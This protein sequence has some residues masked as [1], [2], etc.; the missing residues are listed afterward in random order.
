MNTQ[1][2]LA[3]LM[4]GFISCQSNPEEVLKKEVRS[5]EETRIDL[6]VDEYMGLPTITVTEAF[7]ER[8]AGT[9]N[10]F[11]SE[12]D[13]WWPDPENPEGPYVRRDGVTN[14]DNFVAHRHAMV[15]M[16]RIVG[17]MTSK[18]IL[19][20]DDQY[21]E[22]AMKH[23]KAW[24]V[25]DSTKMNPHMLYS[26]A[27]KGR[28]TGRGIGIIDGLHL[29]EAA[30]SAQLLTNSSAVNQE[31]IETIKGWF[32]EFLNWIYTHEYGKAEMIHP[33]NHG[34]V[35][36]V[37]ASAYALLTENE[38]MISFCKT[39]FKEHLLPSQMAED[40][41]FP[42]ELDRTKPYGYSLFNLDAMSLLTQIL[43]L[44]GDE[45][46]WDFTLEDG[47]GLKKGLEFLYPYIKDKSAW[48]Y[49][50][51]V[52]YWNDW[53]VRQPALVLGGIAYSNSDYIDLWK[54]LEPDP[55]VNEVQRNLVMRYPL[56]WLQN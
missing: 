40:G 17:A 22:E 42:L 36:A 13:Y 10:D 35:W 29:V 18:W 46:L 1:W 38:E 37:Q 11:Y 45:N 26:Q 55:E 39:R 30:R 14:P 56:L 24:F 41:S 4:I 3:L 52:L 7:S 19:T 51:D 20:G 43:T 12:G 23:L 25:N 16:S 31:D 32:S 2:I 9:R 34:T 53:P 54:E 49:E 6:L 33:N 8:S 21:A 15:R 47:R 27:I 48:P 44:A 5:A 50:P 28:Y